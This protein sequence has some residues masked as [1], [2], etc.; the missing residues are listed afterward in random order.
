MILRIWHGRTSRTDADDCQQS[1]D[2]QAT[3]MMARGI[4][5]LRTIDITGRDSGDD[6]VEFCTTRPPAP[7]GQLIR[8]SPPGKCASCRQLPAV[9]LG[10]C[11]LCCQPIRPGRLAAALA[12]GT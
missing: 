5:G 12:A 11:L 3:A 10:T 2:A 4:A 8:C 1:F 6:E 7:F 9:I